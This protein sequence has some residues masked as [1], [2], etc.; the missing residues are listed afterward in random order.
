MEN[1][2]RIMSLRDGTKKMSKSDISEYSRIMLTDTDD[3]ITKKIKKAKTDAMPLPS[4]KKE[5]E[6]MP[7]ALNL[8]TIYSACQDEEFDSVLNKYH[9]KNFSDL[10]TD[11]IDVVINKISPIRDEMNKLTT[12]KKYLQEIL[13][14]G[15]LRAKK[16]ASD[17]LKEVYEVTGLNS[18]S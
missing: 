5:L 17:V 4:T 2:A 15:S 8:L 9:G 12:D 13:N 3:E 18:N 14:F 1:A 11:L 7:E 16:I 6:N 10:K